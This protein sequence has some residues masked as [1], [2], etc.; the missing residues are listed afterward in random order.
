MP[1]RG[2]RDHIVIPGLIDTRPNPLEVL[3]ITQ[4]AAAQLSVESLGKVVNALK[5]AHLQDLHPDTGAKDTAT[6]RARLAKILEASARLDNED[7]GDLRSAY[8]PATRKRKTADKPLSDNPEVRYGKQTLGKAEIYDFGYTGPEFSIALIEGLAN[9]ES[10]ARFD[11]VT[12]MVSNSWDTLAKADGRALEYAQFDLNGH[13]ATVTPLVRKD[14]TAAFKDLFDREAGDVEPYTKEVIFGD[15]GA[16]RRADDDVPFTLS[17]G[18]DDMEA[19]ALDGWLIARGVNTPSGDNRSVEQWSKTGESRSIQRIKLVG[20]V[21]ENVWAQL[22]AGV[23]NSSTTKRNL[24]VL[25]AGDSDDLKKYEGLTFSQ[26]AHTVYAGDLQ[27]AVGQMKGGFSTELKPG[28]VLVGTQQQPDPENS[29][30]GA[31]RVAG[32]I[33]LGTVQYGFAA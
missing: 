11:T 10:I 28:W 14:A 5:R 6:N 7:L 22:N 30:K 15:G 18:E 32:L 31:S 33:P 8:K 25:E 9:P 23:V 27:R 1:S 3:G 16:M 21:Q 2:D 13:I 12:L 24:Q 29:P 20:C 17:T 4:E 19:D 26:V